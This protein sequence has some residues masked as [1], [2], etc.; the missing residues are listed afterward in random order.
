MDINQLKDPLE[1]EKL[2]RNID[3]AHIG[4][5]LV[6]FDNI[7]H[8]IINFDR[9]N[10]LGLNPVKVVGA[11]I[12]LCVRGRM[13]CRI[14]L[15]EHAVEAGEAL[16]VLPGSI[17]QMVSVSDDMETASLSFAKDYF[18][19]IVD[20]SAEMRDY[21]VVRLSESDFDESI[22]VYKM[23]SNRLRRGDE[24]SSRLIAKGYIGVICGIIIDVWK[25]S[26]KRANSGKSRPS[27]LY[28]RYITKVQ[29]DYHRHRNVKHYADILCVSPKYLS[30][31]VKKES[32]RNASDFIDE[33]VIFE[34]KALLMDGR[35]TVQQVAE[36]MEFPNP[37]FFSRFFRKRT[38]LSPTAYRNML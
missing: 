27:E 20:V 16:V 13:A 11:S 19:A 26:S 23:L 2:A 22:N 36:M 9:Q 21:P 33:L 6:L 30:M 32:G 17:M 37:S 18:E 4:H 14:N 1:V 12:F 15:A 29:E 38:G 34:A 7:D 25:N 35:F 10:A 28:T 5:E 3:A 31:V 8:C 24:E